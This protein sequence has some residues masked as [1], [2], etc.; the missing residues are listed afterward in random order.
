MPIERHLPDS[1]Y[2]KMVSQN[3]IIGQSVD[4][5]HCLKRLAEANLL[6]ML[7]TKLGWAK[8]NNYYSEIPKI[9]AIGKKRLK[10]ITA[11]GLDEFLNPNSKKMEEI[12]KGI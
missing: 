8:D 5:P 9:L 10:I 2:G 12:F 3:E 1:E 7:Q 11:M 6:A 4:C